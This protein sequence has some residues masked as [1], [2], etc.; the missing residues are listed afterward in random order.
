MII[1]SFLQHKAAFVTIFVAVLLSG[2]MVL[3]LDSQINAYIEAQDVQQQKIDKVVQTI[4]Q[5]VAQKKLIEQ[6]KIEAEQ[7]YQELIKSDVSRLLPGGST[8]VRKIDTKKPVVF[9]TIDDGMVK[10]QEA[11]DFIIANRLNP[12]LFL[13]NDQ[14]KDNYDYFKQFQ[15]H[16][17][18]IEDHTMTHVK[19]T[20][21]GLAGQKSE[22]CNMRDKIIGIY[23]KT[24]LL[25]RPTYGDYNSNTIAAAKQCGMTAVVNWSAKV[26]GGAIQYQTGNHLVAGDIVLMHFRKEIMQD[27]QAFYAEITAQGLTPAYLSDWL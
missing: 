22:I 3:G 20:T 12:T 14:I 21:L 10:S 13:T 5:Q 15:E 6:Q 16:G 4:Q 1:R 23:G 26:N 25:F 11:A 19:L 24:P 2:S 7:K 27:L 18:E 8:F 17:S 9:L